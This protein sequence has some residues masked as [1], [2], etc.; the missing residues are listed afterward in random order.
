M[1]VNSVTVSHSTN[2]VYNVNTVERQHVDKH[3]HNEI[4]VDK[5][6]HVVNNIQ[7]NE[8]NVARQRIDIFV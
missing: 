6:E 7:Q 3:I 2:Y 1:S 5:T 8:L 4:I